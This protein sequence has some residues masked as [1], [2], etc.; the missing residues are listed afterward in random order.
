[1]RKELF[2]QLVESVKQMKAIEAGRLKPLR[3]TRASDL[4]GDEG[5]DVAALRARFKLSQAKFA[6]LLGISVGTLQNWEQRRRQP[7]GPAKV[8]LRVAA[9]HPEALL[10][11]RQETPR[12]KPESRRKTAV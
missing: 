3:A 12:R 6:A 8:L 2:E 11:L 4:L 5:L 1:M 7:E 9:A 10:S